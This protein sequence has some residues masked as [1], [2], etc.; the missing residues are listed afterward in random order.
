LASWSGKEGTIPDTESGRAV[1]EKCHRHPGGAAKSRP[2]HF[3]GRHK[4]N[5]CVHSV[6]WEKVEILGKVGRV[7]RRRNWHCS[8]VMG[9]TTAGR[10]QSPRRAPRAAAGIGQ[11]WQASLCCSCPLGEGADRLPQISVRACSARDEL[12]V[13]AA[14][15]KAAD[16]DGVR[17]GTCQPVLRILRRYRVASSPCSHAS[18]CPG[19]VAACESSG[20]P[21]SVRCELP[22]W[23]EPARRRV[24]RPGPRSDHTSGHKPAA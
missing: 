2:G 1:R 16:R 18:H 13:S 24:H 10:K 17:A 14:G 12:R 7:I 22:R 15:K 9:M 4:A 19:T 5:I 6:S 20:R 23:K 11:L 3:T 8:R 21:P